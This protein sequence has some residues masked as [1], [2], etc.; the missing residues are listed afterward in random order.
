MDAKDAT[1]PKLGEYMRGY[2]PGKF[3]KYDPSAALQ[4]AQVFNF[5]LAV[6]RQ[7]TNDGVTN[8]FARAFGTDFCNLYNLPGVRHYW[9]ARV[10]SATPPSQEMQEMKNAW[11]P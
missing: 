8:Q 6:Y 3:D 5:Y 9:D 10:K 4:I 2:V 1:A 7:F 11:C